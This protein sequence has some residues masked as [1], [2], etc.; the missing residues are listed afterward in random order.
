MVLGLDLQRAVVEEFGGPRA[1]DFVHF[2][3][4]LPVEGDVG[5]S[6]GEFEARLERAEGDLPAPVGADVQHGR[7]AEVEVVSLPEVGCDDPPP[8]DQPT[9]H[10]RA[11]GEAARSLGSRT[12]L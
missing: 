3:E 11:Y 12:R 7:P 6:I 10:G 9:V 8:T 2:V 5:A 1:S 4:A